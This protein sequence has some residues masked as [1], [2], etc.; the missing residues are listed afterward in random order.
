MQAT[1]VATIDL[2]TKLLIS[3][4]ISSVKKTSD[5]FH[6]NASLDSTKR[7]AAI[8]RVLSN[9]EGKISNWNIKRNE[10]IT[11]LKK[12]GVYNKLASNEDLIVNSS[13]DESTNVLAVADKIL[14]INSTKPDQLSLTSVA[15]EIVLL[16]QIKLKDDTSHTFERLDKKKEEN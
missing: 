1:E 16:E 7:E 15:A 12:I 9:A 11:D 6:A 13:S 5:I 14:E 10:F 2:K 4:Q 3:E 8:R